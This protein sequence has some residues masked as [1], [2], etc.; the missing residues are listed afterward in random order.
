VRNVDA[1]MRSGRFAAY[2]VKGCRF[3]G[4]EP[5]ACVKGYE[6]DHLIPLEVGGGN[7]AR[8]LW[9]QGYRGK[10]NAHTKDALENRLH[11]L[12]C[13]GKLD[14]KVAQT[15]IATDWIAAYRKYGGRAYK[16]GAN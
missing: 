10:Y 14:L 4:K 6:L 3:K 12:V 1:A 11:D 9:P 15:A 8:N 16:S 7:G 2:R 5:A 13:A